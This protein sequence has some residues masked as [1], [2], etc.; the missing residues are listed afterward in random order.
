MLTGSFYAKPE[1]S[2]TGPSCTQG[3]MKRHHPQTVIPVSTEELT[4]IKNPEFQH[5]IP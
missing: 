4:S 3:S 2:D 5:W 1:L